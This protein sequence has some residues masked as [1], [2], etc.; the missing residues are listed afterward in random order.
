M[1]NMPVSESVN[2]TRNNVRTD[3]YPSSWEANYVLGLLF[4][5][6]AFSF[7]DR[8]VLGVMVG[9]IKADLELSDFQFSL[10]QGAAFAILYSVMSI[11]FGRYLFSWKSKQI[12]RLPYC[13]TAFLRYLNP[14]PPPSLGL[15]SRSARRESQRH[16]VC[17]ALWDPTCVETC[18]T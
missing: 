4:L 7:I 18:Q 13:L 12:R 2:D 9:P 8:N 10:L 16:G 1:N 15:R 11:P 5:A 3:E 6:Y 14:P 17:T